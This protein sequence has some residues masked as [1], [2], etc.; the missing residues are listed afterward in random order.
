MVSPPMPNQPVIARWHD[1]PPTVTQ[2]GSR[3]WITRAAN[4]VVVYSEVEPG[5]R[6][7]R[8]DNADEYMLLADDVGARIATPR[9]ELAVGLGT[10][11]I[12][13]PGESQVT[14]AD[15]GRLVRI[16]SAEA[17]DL[18]AAAA[19][20][21]DYAGGA[22][23]VAPLDPW[24]EPVDGYRL[25]SY[26]IPAQGHDGGIMR[27][28]R[29]RNLM[30]NVLVPWAAPRDIRRLSPHSHADFEQASLALSADWVHHLRFPWTPDQTQ[31]KADAHVEVGS[32]SLTVIPPTVIHT[33]RNTT[34]NGRLVDIF[35][36][37]RR[38]FARTP[39][40]VINAADYPLPAD[41]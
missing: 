39:G 38:D 25:R 13:P 31:W 5:A 12:V 14:A 17:A 19:N 27:V 10:L 3:S 16:F 8:A 24:P 6:L 29:S 9:E 40:M 41:A 11:T 33:S 34:P 22:P 2:N 37:P 1:L 21:G 20:A 23:L 28:F 30:V 18:L 32:P 4:F 7:A 26:P 36:P 15:R 35:A